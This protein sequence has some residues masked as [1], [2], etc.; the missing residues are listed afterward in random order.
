MGHD[1]DHGG[2]YVAHNNASGA[3]GN[4]SVCVVLFSQTERRCKAS[5]GVLGWHMVRLVY[6]RPRSMVEM[7]GCESNIDCS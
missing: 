2:Q 1:R 4:S 7:A 3:L 6:L 5:Q